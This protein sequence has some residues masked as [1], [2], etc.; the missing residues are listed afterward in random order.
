MT[1]LEINEIWKN[2]TVGNKEKVSVLKGLSLQV[3]SGEMVAVMG[4]SGSGKTTLVNLISGVDL[5]DS[6]EIR[7]GGQCLSELGKT[8]RALLRRRVLGMVFQD[9]NLIESLSVRENILL[10]MILDKCPAEKQDQRLGELVGPLGIEEIISRSVTEISGGQKQRVAICRALV[11]CPAFLL[12]DEPTGNLDVHSTRDVMRCFAKIHA[13]TGTG[14]LMVTHDTFA[15][16]CC[17][18]AIFLFDGVIGADIRRTGGRVEFLDAI[19]ET[20][21]SLGGGQDDLL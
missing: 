9:F 13:E 2:Y 18:R 5:P 16:S 4:V 11:N 10:P 17:S 21:A 20:L 15:A 12:A 8:E 3:E 7:I 6:G 19:T 14:V 1:S